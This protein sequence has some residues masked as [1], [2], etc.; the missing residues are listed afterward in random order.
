[1]IDAGAL[2]M[3]DPNDIPENAILTPHCGEFE[4]LELRI[5]N[6]ELGIRNKTLGERAQLFAQK[7]NCVV[8]LK[9]A[10]DIVASKDKSKEIKGGNAGMTKGGTG[11]VLAGLVAG[12]YCKNDT[13]ISAVA[14]SYIN[15]K[16]GEDLYKK[17]GY[18]YNASDLADQIPKTMK[19]IFSK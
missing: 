19:K 13:W 3:L 17:M 8:L 6:Y 11:D 4:G 1:V 12:L 16:A 10:V 14:A 2:Q 15:K 7:Y 5:T 18:W 9:G